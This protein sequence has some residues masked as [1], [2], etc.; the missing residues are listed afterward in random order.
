MSEKLLKT[1][2][3]K[4]YASKQTETNRCKVVL[5]G[6]YRTGQLKSWS[7]YYNYPIF[8]DDKVTDEAAESVNE[9]W[10]FKG[11]TEPRYFETEF[12]GI[13]TRDELV[14]EYGYP[15]KGKPHGV[16]R[17][18][19]FKLK[20]DLY[21]PSVEYAKSV[22]IRVKDFKTASSVQ[23]KLKSY[24][25]SPERNDQS[26][27]NLLPS[28]VSKIPYNI[29]RVCEDALQLDFFNIMDVND[30]YN[31]PFP[32]PKDGKF[33]FIDLFAGIG[34]IR[35]GFQLN[36]G[37]CV[38]SSEWDKDAATT[39]YYNFGERPVG[40]IR[41]ID[42]NSIPDFDVLLAGFPC[43]P[44]SIIG[45]KE[46]FKHETQGTLFFDIEKILLAKKPK[47]F[48]LENV[49]NLTAH[50]NGRTFKVILSH[51]IKAGYDVHYKVLNALDYGVPQKRERIIICGFRKKV[52]FEFPPPIPIDNRKTVADIIDPDAEQDKTLFVRPA[53]RNSRLARL[54][55][56][57]YPRPY[58]SHENVAGSI[59]PHSFSCALRAGASANYILINDERR[60]SARE[61]LRIQGFPDEFKI[62][63]NYGKIK[64]QTGNSVAVPVIM[65]V[66]ERIVAKLDEL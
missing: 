47:A 55:D 24:L 65:A 25:K 3:R 49:R 62:V 50:D 2:K 63:V 27:E 66:A 58:I 4:I 18:I 17:Y 23:S 33:T 11:T 59:T 45:D 26:T 34:G 41:K 30:T 5:I 22:I 14:N 28:I 1:K 19:L 10:L 21:E 57:N 15:A 64:H 42:P 7:G 37:R 12:I 8:D 29:L 61:M 60:P 38:F 20:G 9:L 44:F 52:D 40:D 46:G 16:G 35:L 6:T 39:Y 56:K 31:F 13:K 43:Q 36:G 51:L 48:M 53:I 32:A 54:K